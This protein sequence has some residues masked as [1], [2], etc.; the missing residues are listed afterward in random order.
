MAGG[1]GEVEEVGGLFC[2]EEV[3]GVGE[4]DGDAGEA[5]EGGDEGGVY[6]AGEG[7]DGV[8]GCS[9]PDCFLYC[10]FEGEVGDVG[11][12]GEV[13]CGGADGAG[14]DGARD[15]VVV[16]AG[17]EVGGGEEEFAAAAGEAVGG[18]GFYF[19]GGEDVSL[20]FDPAVKLHWC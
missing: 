19:T 17:G 2:G 12:D 15:D 8:F 18:E 10:G 7:D 1:E 5:G 20:F 14:R 16:V 6:A 11:G 3:V 13:A 9:E 4:A